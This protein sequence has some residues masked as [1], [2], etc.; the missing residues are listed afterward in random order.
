MLFHRTS[1]LL[2]FLFLCSSAALSQ[3]NPRR[4]GG[5]RP[6][7]RG[8]P[9][10]P[11]AGQGGARLGML[12]IMKALD[13]D[14]DGTLSA[15]EIQN[16]SKALAALDKNSDGMLSAEE[17]RPDPSMMARPGQP[18][19]A[20][21]PGQPGRPGAGGAPTGEMLT[22]MFD[23]RDTDKDGKLSGDEIPE[24]MRENVSR[25]DTNGDGAIDREEMQKAMAR[26][27][28]QA[29]QQRGNRGNRGTEGGEG[30]KP[31][32]PTEE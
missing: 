1:A 3:D 24:R 2:A 15:A 11:G 12:P 7:G 16:A 10:L 9:G 25:V 30:V 28:E 4:P 26:M 14:Q 21:T 23:A 18:G 29:G 22:R 27:A 19:A 6:E 17:M 13:A 32:R 20:G 5:E 8:R 31:K